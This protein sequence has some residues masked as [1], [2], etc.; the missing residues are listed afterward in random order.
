MSD[1]RPRAAGEASWDAGV[2]RPGEVIAGKYRVD[3]EL[4]AGAM[5]VVLSGHHLLLQRPVALKVLRQA[6][7][8][9]PVV[10]ARFLREARAALSIQSAHVVRVMDVGTLD[11]GAPFMVMEHLDG[12][13]LGQLLARRGP[14]PVGEAVGYVL[15]ACDAV[16]EAH[17]RGIVH[18]D[19]KPANL[20]LTRRADG[21]ALIKV[22]DFGIS[23]ATLGEAERDLGLTESAAIL[24]SPIYMSPEQVR[25]SKSVDARADVWALGVVLYRLTSGAAPFEGSTFSSL[26]AAI[27]ADPPVPLRERFPAVPAALDAVVTRCLEKD[28]AARFPDVSA[29]AAA[30]A[31]LAD[32]AEQASTSEATIEAPGASATATAWDPAPPVPTRGSSWPLV[33]LGGLAVG[34]AAMVAVSLRSPGAGVST[35]ATSAS[36]VASTAS[37]VASST[38]V[39]SLSVPSSTSASASASTSTS[40]PPPTVSAPTVGVVPTATLTAVAAPKVSEKPAPSSAPAPSAAATAVSSANLP[41]KPSSSALDVPW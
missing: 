17:Q 28:P 25:D 7:A 24:G 29:L 40:T 38:A 6:S 22:L 20:F 36:P 27:A 2:P 23:K 4:G 11:G 34:I 8:S 30:L 21:R 9:R 3:G 26:C 1:A 13:D 16:A 14:L 33:A 32:R 39:A 31:P 5:G 41:P 19:L 12:E 15:Q 35:P 37:A 18:R 10:V